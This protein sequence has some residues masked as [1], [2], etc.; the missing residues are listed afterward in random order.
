MKSIFLVS[1]VEDIRERVER[2]ESVLGELAE[3]ADRTHLLSLNA[4]IVA[5][6][7]RKFASKPSVTVSLSNLF[8]TRY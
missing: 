7:A 6:H 5:A 2:M 8:R 1:E 3:I 4:C